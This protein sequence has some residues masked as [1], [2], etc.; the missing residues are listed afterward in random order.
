SQ[1]SVTSRVFQV[2][3]EMA[4]QNKMLGQFDLVGI[5]SAPLGVPQI[6]VT[7]EIDA[8]GILHVSARDL[9]TGR[10]QR[11]EV[12]ASSGLSEVEIDRMINEAERHRVADVE[13]KEL[14]ELRNTA[15]GLIH[16][17]E[18]SLEEY[19]DVLSPLDLEEIRTDV[20]TL[21]L[22]LDTVDPDELRLAIQNL[23]QSAYRI[24]DAMYAQSGSGK[25]KGK[26]GLDAALDDLD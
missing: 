25:G 15:E 23:E 16:T 24:A 8:D 12:R 2:Q 9:G 20:Q 4:A 14:V 5:S 13:R 1:S 10:E 7:F 22:S 17:T 21:R 18:R 19:G 11:V 26:G 6:E 3:R